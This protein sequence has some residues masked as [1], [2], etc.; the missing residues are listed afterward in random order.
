[1]NH[2]QHAIVNTMIAFAHEGHLRIGADLL[3][4][5]VHRDR[6][7]VIAE[8]QTCDELIVEEHPDRVIIIWNEPAF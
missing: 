3:A 4:E 2:L 1:M 6:D 8:A 7:V 5:T